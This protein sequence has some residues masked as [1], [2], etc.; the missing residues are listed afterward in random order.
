MA[1][2]YWEVHLV[3]KKDLLAQLKTP[4]FSLLLN[5]LRA[6][7]HTQLLLISTFC[8][9]KSSTAFIRKMRKKLSEAHFR[10]TEKET[11]AD[12]Y[13]VQLIMSEIRHLEAQIASEV[14]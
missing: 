3:N 2:L 8:D 1:S 5:D 7:H 12:I 6:Y 10:N 13:A 9:Y 4:P 11:I 14:A